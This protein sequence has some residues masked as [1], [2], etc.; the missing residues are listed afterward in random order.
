M[1]VL[2]VGPD[3]LCGV[4]GELNFQEQRELVLFDGWLEL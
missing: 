3:G 2:R 1:C 4:I